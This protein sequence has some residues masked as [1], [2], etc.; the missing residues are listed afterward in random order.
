MLKK[1]HKFFD[2][3][4]VKPKPPPT[5]ISKPKPEIKKPPVKK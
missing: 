1:I 3:G 5:K 2:G 4:W